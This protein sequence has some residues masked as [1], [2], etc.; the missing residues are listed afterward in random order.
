[1][2]FT[3]GYHSSAQPTD[4]GLS[5]LSVRSPQKTLCPVCKIPP[6]KSCVSFTGSGPLLQPLEPIAT[7]NGV[8]RGLAQCMPKYYYFCNANVFIETILFNTIIMYHVICI[9][10][11]YNLNI[12]DYN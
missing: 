8:Q 10:N 5:P 3:R 12:C 2:L 6:V 4:T 11:L 9:Y 7:P 1:M